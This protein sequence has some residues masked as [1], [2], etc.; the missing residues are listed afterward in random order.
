MALGSLDDGVA[1]VAEAGPAT[2]PA[3]PG[4]STQLGFA[5]LVLRAN[6]LPKSD[7]R[8]LCYALHTP[9]GSRWRHKLSAVRSG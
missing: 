9:A 2:R 8:L 1:F 4:L 7:R 5:I 6:T 3:Q